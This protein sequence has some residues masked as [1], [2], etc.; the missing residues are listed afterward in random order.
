MTLSSARFICVYLC[1]LKIGVTY[2]AETYSENMSIN[3]F[4]FDNGDHFRVEKA[5]VIEMYR[6]QYIFHTLYISNRAFRN[7][8]IFVP[9][10]TLVYGIFFL[11]HKNAKEIDPSNLLRL[12]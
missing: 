10:L 8:F 9:Y 4:S 12:F 3:S 11:P 7:Y 1:V 6:G 5:N 2:L